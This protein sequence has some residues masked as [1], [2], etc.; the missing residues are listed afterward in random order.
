MDDG[1][2]ILPVTADSHRLIGGHRRATASENRVAR[3][4]P[5]HVV[6]RKGRL[7][8]PQLIVR[9]GFEFQDDAAFAEFLGLQN[10]VVLTATV[11][12]GDWV[13]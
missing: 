9:L 13:P 7:D 10:Y 6:G 8:H 5:H 12:I 11:D 3:G 2:H 4:Q 1:T